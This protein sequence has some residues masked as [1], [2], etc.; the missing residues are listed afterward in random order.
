MTAVFLILIEATKEE[1]LAGGSTQRTELL[2]W[3]RLSAAIR[4]AST[5]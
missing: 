1:S 5:I 3:E 2:L 4:K